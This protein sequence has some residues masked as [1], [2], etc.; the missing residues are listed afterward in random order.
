MRISWLPI[1]L[2]ATLAAVSP[3]PAQVAD[4]AGVLPG[5]R[6]V[7]E[8]TDEITGDIKATTTI[9]V[10]DVSEKEINTRWS[11]RGA[12]GAPQVVFDDNWRQ[13]ERR[14]WK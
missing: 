8:V 10:V 6:W 2:L 5:D 3:A 1:V 14:N 12:T 7:Y 9:V 11:A 13:V 4:I